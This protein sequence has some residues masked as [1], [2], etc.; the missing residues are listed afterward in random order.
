M[1]KIQKNNVT[2]LIDIL[3]NPNDS[4]PQSAIDDLANTKTSHPEY[5]VVN[6]DGE[7]C[8]LGLDKAKPENFVMLSEEKTTCYVIP[9][10]F[11]NVRFI[12]ASK[13]FRIKKNNVEG[14]RMNK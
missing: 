4:I 10:K 5:L 11:G 13:K 14:F 2:D 1:I 9:D 7:V 12:F 3:Q 6:D 8:E